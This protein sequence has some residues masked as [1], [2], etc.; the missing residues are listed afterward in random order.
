MFYIPKLRSEEN[1]SSLWQIIVVC[2]A[3][4]TVY[5]IFKKLKLVFNYF[6]FLY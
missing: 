4:P 3:Q 2:N 1:G 5:S 6:I